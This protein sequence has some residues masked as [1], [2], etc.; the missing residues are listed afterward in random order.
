MEIIMRNVGRPSVYKDGQQISVYLPRDIVNKISEEASARGLSRSAFIEE[1]LRLYLEGG[2]D[3]VDRIRELETRVKELQEYNDAL[4]K[5]IEELESQ[6]DESET[7]NKEEKKEKDRLQEWKEL[8][9]REKK[10]IYERLRE[11]LKA[12]RAKKDKELERKILRKYNEEWQKGLG[13]L[14][15][16]FRKNERSGDEK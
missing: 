4:I 15:K 2:L 1:V 11:E 9:E 7:E 8:V 10:K 16:E 6:L 12:V 3:N 13:E 14:E 5:R